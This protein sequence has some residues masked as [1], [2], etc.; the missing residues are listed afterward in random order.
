MISTIIYITLH[1]T[2]IAFS[3]DNIEMVAMEIFAVFL[4]LRFFLSF[5]VFLSSAFFSHLRFLSPLR[6]FLVSSSLSSL[7]FFPLLSAVFS[8]LSPP[9]RRCSSSDVQRGPGRSVG[10]KL[11]SLNSRY[12]RFLKRRFPRFFQLYHTFVEG[13]FLVS[14][15]EKINEPVDVASFRTS[16]YHLINSVYIFLEA[17][18]NCSL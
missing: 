2:I 1:S 14:S 12:E 15:M 7:R 16:S 13:E 10:T 6:F 5:V 3:G 4:S 8:L 11:Q 9:C 17:V 18:F